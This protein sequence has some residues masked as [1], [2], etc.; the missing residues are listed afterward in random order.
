MKTSF[1]KKLDSFD[2][3]HFI[4]GALD[5]DFMIPVTPEEWDH[6]QATDIELDARLHKLRGLRQQIEKLD[7]SST[8]NKLYKKKKTTKFKSTAV[9]K[10]KNVSLK[11]KSKFTNVTTVAR[12]SQV[13]YMK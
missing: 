1:F 7:R 3:N 5:R 2:L 12:R 6:M 9:A 8:K 4:S 11:Q 10:S 13:S